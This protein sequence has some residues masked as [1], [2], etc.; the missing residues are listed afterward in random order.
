MEWW[1][2]MS[3]FKFACPICSQHISAD[4]TASGTALECPTCF[5]KI[6]VPQAPASEDTKFILS[7]SQAAK[8]RPVRFSAASG[9]SLDHEPVRHNLVPGIAL[10]LVLVC[11]GS[12]ILLVWHGKALRRTQ[13]TE[14]PRTNSVSKPVENV[15][16]RS[17]YAVP[18]NILW[19]MELTNVEIPD[20]PLAGKIHGNGFQCERAT[21]NGGTLSLR[22]GKSFQPDLAVSITLFVPRSDQLSG[23]TVVITSTRQ[24]PVPVVTLRWKEAPQ[25]TLQETISGG[26][27]MKLSFGRVTNGHLPGRLY[28]ALPDE[29][30][31]YAAGTF[32][33]EIRGGRGPGR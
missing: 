22:Q 2:W 1:K 33:A 9:P 30:R 27:A 3:E 31:S 16:F 17:P 8:P 15:S 21:V 20:T 7:A 18:T 25:Q 32:D 23:R 24:P 29:A 12:A 10:L 19:T 5:Q 26:Y 11:A 4:A 6:I 28:I 14:I 13:R